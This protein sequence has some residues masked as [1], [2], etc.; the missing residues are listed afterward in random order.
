MEDGQGSESGGSELTDVEDVFVS[1]EADMPKRVYFDMRPSQEEVNAHNISHL[2]YRSWCPHC[3]RGKARRR[4]HRKKNRQ[5]RDGVPVISM[6][7]MW[8]KGKKTDPDSDQKGN[9]ILVMHCRDSKLTWSRV[10]L[11]KGVDPYS[12]KVACDMIAFTGHK[13][14]ILKSDGES[15]ITALVNA[16]KA[17]SDLEMGV[18]VSPVGASKS[19][20]EIE[21][22]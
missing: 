22:Q 12:V 20:G 8:L 9:P 17:S 4:N 2:P 1:E 15:S 16:I 5:R 19:N 14:V 7:Y 10:L 13:R 11:K 18:E 6:D 3:V 21:E